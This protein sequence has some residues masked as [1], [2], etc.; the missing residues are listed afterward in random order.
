MS[1]FDGIFDAI[2]KVAIEEAISRFAHETVE[3]VMRDGAHHRVMSAA[4]ADKCKDLLEN[5][6]EVKQKLRDAI[7]EAID[8]QYIPKA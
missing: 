2:A 7:V 3:S 4:I 5:D 6:I 8:H 1:K